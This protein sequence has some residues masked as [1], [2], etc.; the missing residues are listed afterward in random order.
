MAGRNEQISRIALV[1]VYK[2][3]LSEPDKTFVR[4]DFQHQYGMSGTEKHRSTQFVEKY[5]NTLI[6]LGLIEKVHAIY[7]SG[8]RTVIS[9][10]VKGYRLMKGGEY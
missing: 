1:K 7:K 6:R 5:L 9:R 3:F 2:I 4:S 8:L 10:T